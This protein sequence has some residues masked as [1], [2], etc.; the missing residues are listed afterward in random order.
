MT[1]SEMHIEEINY[2]LFKRIL[3][4]VMEQLYSCK[5]DQDRQVLTENEYRICCCVA[6]AKL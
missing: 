6:K 1:A 4:E 3:Q 2:S 5:T